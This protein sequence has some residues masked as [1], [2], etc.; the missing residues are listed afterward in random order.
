LGTDV[1]QKGFETVGGF[2]YDLVGSVPEEGKALD[3]ESDRMGLKIVVEKVKGQ[4]IKTVKVTLI[5][6]FPDS[7]SEKNH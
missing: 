7:P 5:P 3:Y 2:I 6:A 1:A 4:R